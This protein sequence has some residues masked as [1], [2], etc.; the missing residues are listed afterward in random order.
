MASSGLGDFPLIN[1]RVS[2]EGLTEP[3]AF[4]NAATAASTILGDYFFETVAAGSDAE[5]S[6]SGSGQASGQAAAT[7]ATAGQAAGAG[8]ASGQ[9]SA[10]AATVLSASGSGG[11]EAVGEVAPKDAD[12]FSAGSGASSGA[13]ASIAAAAVFSAGVGSLAAEGASES[14]G[15]TDAEFSISGSGTAS[16]AASSIARSDALSA[17][18]GSADGAAASLAASV[19]I[20]DGAGTAE[21]VGATGEEPA[22]EPDQPE[23]VLSGGAGA[24]HPDLVGQKKKR[25]PRIIRQGEA[26]GSAVDQAE[27]DFRT[28][29]EAVRIRDNPKRLEAVARK[30]AAMLADLERATLI[31]K[32][33]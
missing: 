19:A 1:D 17:G 21:G 10:L 5:A 9:A 31:R 20:A 3:I 26:D 24:M 12:A 13:A 23:Q 15:F 7:A 27:S 6:V 32:A 16:S 18:V 30:R 4:G 14:A 29:W 11:L 22:E 8:T 25:K 2:R 28:L 33:S